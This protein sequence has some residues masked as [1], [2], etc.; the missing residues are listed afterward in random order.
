MIPRLYDSLPAGHFGAS[1]QMLFVS[2]PRQVGK[3]TT[4]RAAGAE[5]ECHYLNWDNQDHRLVLLRGPAALAEFVDLDV[6]RADKPLL[7]LDEVHKY[8]GWR[9][10]LKGTFDT[11]GTRV[12]MLVTGSAMLNVFSHAGDSLMGRYLPYRMHPLSV[13]E[14]IRPTL[15]QHGELVRPP[16]RPPEG[17]LDALLDFGGFPEPFERGEK[18]FWN[19]WRRLRTQLLFKEDLRDLTRIQELGQMEVL[20]QLVASSAG[21]LVNYTWFAKQVRVSVNTVRRWLETLEALYYCFAVRPWYRNVAR[22]LRKEPKY[23]LWDWSQIADAGAR[24]ENLVACALLKAAHLWTDHGFGEFGL[25]FLRDKEKREVDFVVTRDSEPWFL[26]EVKSSAN[27]RVSPTL[28]YFQAQTHAAHAFQVA[29]HADFVDADC[30]TRKVPTVVPASTF[31]S[32]LV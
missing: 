23:Y 10:L 14:L 5:R 3:T 27:V 16:L 31:L 2:G 6:L 20:A 1:R 25:H 11:Y 19:Q 8:P 17:A 29:A 18:R 22:A 26:V 7:V 9:D 21:Q 15:P 13:A 28:G 32:Q 24:A 4:A 12:D 30:F